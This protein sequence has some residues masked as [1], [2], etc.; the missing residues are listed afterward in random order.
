MLQESMRRAGEG[1]LLISVGQIYALEKI[2][3]AHR[4]HQLSMNATS[5]LTGRI[6]VKL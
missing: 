1:E 5:I 4:K 6:V 3:E 2:R